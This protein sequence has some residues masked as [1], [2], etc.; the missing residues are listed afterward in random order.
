MLPADMWSRKLGVGNNTIWLFSLSVKRWP[1]VETAS[2]LATRGEREFGAF[3]SRLW[4]FCSWILVPQASFLGVLS[5]ALLI[6]VP[7]SSFF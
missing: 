6:L 7:G 1:G 2:V 4:A 5:W 3:W